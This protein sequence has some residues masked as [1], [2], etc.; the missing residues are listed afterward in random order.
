MKKKEEKKKSSARPPPR[1]STNK[2]YYAR[3]W[4]PTT[5]TRRRR[6]GPCCQPNLASRRVGCGYGKPVARG[7]RLLHSVIHPRL[8]S[9]V[10]LWW[11]GQSWQCSSLSPQ[12]R[13]EA[14]SWRKISAPL[15]LEL[16]WLEAISQIPCTF[17]P[18]PLHRPRLLATLA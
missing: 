11:V 18:P 4:W 10:V 9:D 2:S 5:T 13:A 16:V 14:Q 6:V 3:T 12:I 7:Q 8:S 17:L 1:N 15:Q